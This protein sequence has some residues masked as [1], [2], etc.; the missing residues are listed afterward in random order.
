MESEGR[1]YKTG[2]KDDENS[3]VAVA[4]TIVNDDD[5]ILRLMG[6]HPVKR[7]FNQNYGMTYKTSYDY[8]GSLSRS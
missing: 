4:V 2:S 3:T 7:F 5:M 6:Y 8:E 1:E